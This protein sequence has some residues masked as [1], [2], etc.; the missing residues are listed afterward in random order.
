MTTTEHQYILSKIKQ[1]ININNRE[2]NFKCNYYIT[3]DD[4]TPFYVA[5]TD[6]ETLDNNPKL[7]FQI[8][9][10]GIFQGEFTQTDNTYKP[11]YIILKSDA[12]TNVKIVLSVDELPIT[13]PE[14][15]TNYNM[16]LIIFIM[17]IIV[18]IVALYLSPFS[19]KQSSKPFTVA[20]SSVLNKL[21]T[22]PLN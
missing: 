14:K 17:T 20:S 3:S 16:K 10:T 1:V 22:I 5:I 4:N 15:K 11:Y 21:K 12:P 19:L 8:A 18:I 9:T 7:D 2:V 13:E 6:Q